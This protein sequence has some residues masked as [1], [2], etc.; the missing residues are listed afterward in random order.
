MARTRRLI[1]SLDW[2][3]K[4]FVYRNF[5]GNWKRRTELVEYC[6]RVVDQ[7]LSEK[8][9]V[10]EDETQDS[11]TKRKVQGHIFEEQVKVR[12]F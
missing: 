7:S 10:L 3:S 11:A 2:Y 12:R 6:V 8:R 4:I 1:Q 9:S 5:S